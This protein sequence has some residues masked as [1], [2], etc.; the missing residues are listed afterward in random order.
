MRQSG[1]LDFY[2]DKQLVDYQEQH[3]ENYDEEEK[4]NLEKAFKDFDEAYRVDPDDLEQKDKDKE[5]ERLKRYNKLSTREKHDKD[6]KRKEREKL[7]KDVGQYRS[8]M[9][10]TDVKVDFDNIFLKCADFEATF[11]I[12]MSK[13]S[14]IGMKTAKFKS[15]FSVNEWSKIH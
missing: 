15:R 8:L 14:N 2:W 12:P 5:T 4:A 6:Q 11:T 13:E 7:L 9:K 10:F 1:N 3:L